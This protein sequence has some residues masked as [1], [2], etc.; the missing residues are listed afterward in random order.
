M[1]YAQEV[2]AKS[3]KLKGR[4]IRDKRFVDSVTCAYYKGTGVDPKYGNMSRCPICGASGQIKVNPPVV[5]CRKCFGTGREGGDL[6][7]LACKGVGVVSVS[8]EAG[9]CPACK[10]TGEAGIFYCTTCKGQGIA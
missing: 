1:E 5:T 8:Q 7:C 4:R 6:S 9:T 2:L 10:G 3:G